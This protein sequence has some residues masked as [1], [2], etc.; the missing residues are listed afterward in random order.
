LNLR[1]RYYDK[2]GHGA[3]VA[4]M[5][6]TGVKVG[7]LHKVVGSSPTVSIAFCFALG[8]LKSRPL[9]SEFSVYSFAPK[10]EAIW[11][12]DGGPVVN[13]WPDLRSE[14]RTFS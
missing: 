9:T 5:L 1:A 2:R 4:R 3:A 13:L 8:F 14:N 12:K 6:C 10:F 11:S 7:N